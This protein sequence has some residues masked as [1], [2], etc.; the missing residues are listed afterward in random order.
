VKILLIGGNGQ[1]G[2]ELQRT[3][4]PLGEVIVPCREQLD[5]TLP[6]A[7]RETILHIK[8]DWIVNAG[9]YTAVDRAEQERDLTF[10]V[11]AE[12]PQI[13]AEISAELGVALIHYSTDYVFDGAG[14]VPFDEDSPIRPLNVYG[15]SKAAGDLAIQ[16]IHSKHLIFRTSWVYGQ[17]GTNF[18]LTMQRL[19]RER[20]ELHIINDQIGAPTWS[21][22][23]AEATALVM[24]QTISTT[25][26]FDRSKLWGT[27]HLTNRGETSWFGFACAILKAMRLEKKLHL[28][29]IPSSDYP[30]RALRPLNSRLSHGKLEKVF[31]VKLPD[32]QVA[33]SQV[34]EK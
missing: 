16:K 20:N 11:N 33:L 13:L 14:T 22:H 29:S 3:L 8:P 26:E 34:T 7:L 1:I 24:T 4:S 23:I 10:A 27:Y 5:L 32:W 25:R 12:A 31:G 2:W 30:S 21:R 28:I 17:R 9:A 6:K 18:F 15:T 19:M